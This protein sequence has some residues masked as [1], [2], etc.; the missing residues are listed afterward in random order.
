MQRLEVSGA[1]R[2]PNGSLDVKGLMGREQQF[3]DFGNSYDCIT[4]NGRFMWF[5]VGAYMN[6]VMR[7]R[8]P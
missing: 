7:I 8:V 4:V 2:S 5:M 3:R 1:V 6:T